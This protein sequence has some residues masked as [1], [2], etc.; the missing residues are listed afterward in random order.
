MKPS[1][2]IETKTACPAGMDRRRFLRRG[3]AALA[4]A[5]LV[6]ASFLVRAQPAT[7]G[8]AAAPRIRLGIVGCG[9]RGGWI[10]RLFHG[11]GG[12]T[13]H[14]VA[15]YFQEV[16]DACGDAVGVDQARR[17]SGLS[18]FKRLMESGVEAV[19]LETPPFWFPEHVQFAVAQGLHVFLAKPVA[20]D[21]PGCLAVE[22]AARSVQGKRCFLVDYQMPTDPSNIEVV[23]RIHEG[24]IGPVAAL[25]SQYHAGSF[26]D[27][28]LTDSIASRL[29]S[30]IW[31]NDDAIGGGYHVNA[32]IH[33]IDAALWIAGS[34]P[35]SAT[36]VS[37]RMRENPQGDSHDVY[38][39]LFQFENGLALTHHG[40]HL[41][42]QTGFDVYAEAQG[43]HGHARIYYGG[44]AWLKARDDG[45]N[46]DVPNLYEGGAVRNID[47]FHRSVA[48]EDF[49]NPTVA[50]SIDGTLA[51]LLGREAG[52]RRGTVAMAELL[53]Q[54]RRLEIDLT[55]LKA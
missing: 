36:G 12:Y 22:A 26:S 6:P 15:D 1:P 49:S 39:L 32:C 9:G 14:A 31:V 53:R 25:S 2:L 41:N 27:P 24:Q 21:V 13:M 23:R 45:F 47:L 10:A 5:P 55:G 38:S 19:A 17:F 33:A 35:V 40:K 7:V 20:V 34:R 43:R 50:R 29:R 54:N 4:V 51:T 37:H 8:S 44:R 48:V 30:L 46:G 16:A 3:L 18:G 28:P 11:H 52:V 42:N